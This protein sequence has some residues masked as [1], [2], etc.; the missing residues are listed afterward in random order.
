MIKYAYIKVGISTSDTSRLGFYNNITFQLGPDHFSFHDLE[1]GILRANRKAPFALSHPFGPKDDRWRLSMPT[2]DCRILFAL[3]FGI[4]SSQ[5]V[6]NFTDVGIDQEL[7]IVAQDFCQED[8]QVEIKEREMTVQ[9]SE[10]FK[11]HREDF[12]SPTADTLPKAVVKYLRGNKKSALERM[13]LRGPSSSVKVKFLPY[14]WS[15]NASDF[16]PFTG[17]SVKANSSRFL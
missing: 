12:C 17:G 10:I 2:V 7:R 13:L 8:A 9:L 15:T 16:V 6:N 11:W 5:P 3:H 14:H 1:H 4:K